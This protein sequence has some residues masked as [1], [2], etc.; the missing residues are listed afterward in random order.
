M[1]AAQKTYKFFRD[2]LSSAAHAVECV[3][4]LRIGMAYEVNEG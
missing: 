2:T 1:N 3:A 4:R